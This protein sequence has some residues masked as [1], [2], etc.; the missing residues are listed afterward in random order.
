MIE[1]ISKRINKLYNIANLEFNFN[2]ESKVT[3][4]YPRDIVHLK[5]IIT[6]EEYI[7][8]L[9]P[10]FAKEEE[11]KKRKVLFNLREENDNDNS[12][13]N[14]R[15]KNQNVVVYYTYSLKNNLSPFKIIGELFQ[16][17]EIVDKSGLTNQNK[18]RGEY[19]LT[20]ICNEPSILLYL[21]INTYEKFVKQRQESISMKNTNSILEIPFFKGLNANLFKEKYFSFF[22]LYNYKNGEFIFRQEEKMKNIYFIK[23]G[24]IELTMKASIA[25][26][27]NILENIKNK[28]INEIKQN[29]P[30]INYKNKKKIILNNEEEENL[31]IINKFKND[32]NVMKWRIIRIN[33]KD[34]IGLNEILDLNNKYYMNAKCISYFG[35]IYSIDYIKFYEMLNDDKGMKNMFY[36]YCIRK[37]NLIYERLDSIIK[38][39]IKDKFKAYKNKLLKNLSLKQTKIINI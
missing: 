31:E 3:F 9:V 29:D 14:E 7:K 21:N 19:A 36:D 38:I 17:N 16:D 10:H 25:D 22:T 6:V 8:R 30:I 12:Y 11:N 20:A 39:Y 5:E 35:E 27:N 23:S 15:D 34:I 1:I 24:E 37:E 4:E 32:K 28:N 13:I 33:Y 18:K 2:I 26:I